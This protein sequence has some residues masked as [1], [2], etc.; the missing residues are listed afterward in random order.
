MKKEYLELSKI[1]VKQINEFI[2]NIFDTTEDLRQKISNLQTAVFLIARALIGDKGHY[3]FDLK[4][5][6]KL[7]EVE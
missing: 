5:I 3:T 7:V 4:E 1:D 2:T 6:K